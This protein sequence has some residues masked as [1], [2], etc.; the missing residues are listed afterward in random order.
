M[1][2][3]WL[4]MPNIDENGKNIA[5]QAIIRP[6]QPKQLTNISKTLNQGQMNKS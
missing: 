5:D 4:N 1:A 3:S 6:N 2:K